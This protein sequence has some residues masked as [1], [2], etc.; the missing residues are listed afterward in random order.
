M[1]NSQ[2]KIYPNMTVL[3]IVSDN[4]GAID[5]FKKYNAQAGEC[6][7]CASL[8]ETV[9]DVAEKYGID[10]NALLNDLNNVF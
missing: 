7:C 2:K 3:D 6:I 9:E 4:K 8:F 10:L 5:I 1:T